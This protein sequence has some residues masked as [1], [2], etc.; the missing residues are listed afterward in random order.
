[1]RIFIC[2]ARWDEVVMPLGGSVVG[3]FGAPLGDVD[4]DRPSSPQP[5]TISPRTVNSE[6]Q[7]ALRVAG[8]TPPDVG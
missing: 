8:M 5:A 3:G 6:A 4:G 2:A 7:T 1:M